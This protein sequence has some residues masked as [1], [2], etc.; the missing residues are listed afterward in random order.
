MAAECVTMAQL[1][2]CK[3]A[4]AVGAAGAAVRRHGDMGTAARARR[5]APPW[6]EAGTYGTVPR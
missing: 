6:W 5:A 2:A 4:V 1:P 3:R